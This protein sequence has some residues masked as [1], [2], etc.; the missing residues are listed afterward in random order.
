[1][2]AKTLLLS[3]AAIL[4]AAFVA[5]PLAAQSITLDPPPVRQPLDE[6]GVDLSSGSIAVP[7]STIAI[8]GG[9]GLV[10]SRSRVG[11]GWRH[12]YILSVTKEPV[13]GVHTYTVQIGGSAREFLKDT[14]GDFS[15]LSGERGTM[16][17]TT[18][19]IIYT[20][21]G[22][23]EYRF[24]KSLVA[25]GES[26][27]EDVEAVGT[28]IEAPNG[29]KTTLTY[30]GGTYTLGAATIHT[31]RLQSV[32]NNA[33]YQLKF[34]YETN[35]LNSSTV[36]DW[37][38]IDK[39]T[40]INNAEEYCNPAADSCS[41]AG[42]WPYLD[43]AVT[44]S[45]TE[46]LETVTDVLGRQS[47]FRNDGSERLIGVKRPSETTD[48]VVI[49]YDTNSRVSSVTHQG[50]Y[51]RNYTWTESSGELTAVAS[52]SLGRKRTTV[53]DIDKGVIL[54][55]KDA[56]NNETEY[57][58]DGQDRLTEVEAPEGN[59]TVITRDDRGRVTEVRQ[60]A[61]PGSGLAD[62]VTSAT[63][64]ALTSAPA[65]G[66]S[67]IYCNTD[68]TCDSPLTTTDARGKVTD[69]TYDQTHGGVLTVQLPADAGSVR[70]KSTF[71]YASEYARIRNSSGT[72]VQAADPI[73]KPVS[74]KRCRIG[75]SCSG[76]ANEQVI[77]VDYDNLQAA[78][79]QPVTITRKVGNGTLA[80]TSSFT[81]TPLGLV[82]TTDGPLA[83]S[84]DLSKNRYD[85]A[86][87]LVGT[88][89]PDPNG[90]ST[91]N[92]PLATRLTR[93]L[94]GQVTVTEN[95]TVP[96]LTDTDWANFAGDTRYL[97]S[98]DAFGRVET[99]AHVFK[100]TAAQ[101]SITQ[102]SYDAAGRLECTAQR[103]NAPLS[104]TTLPGDACTPMTAGANGDDRITR[105]YYDTADRVTEVWSG[106]GTSLAQQSV[107]MSY[108]ANGQTQWVE[109]AMDNRTEYT[110]DGFDRNIRI[111]YPDPGAA[112]TVKASD[113]EAITYDAGGNI[114]THRTR[115][116]ETFSYTYD[117]LSR[118]T[119]K[120]VPTRSGLAATHTR[121]VY[122]GYDLLGGLTYANFDSPTG[123][124]LSF[125]YDALG[126]LVSAT[127]NLDSQSRT[128]AY[129][130]DAAG[131][132]TRIT[133]PDNAWWTHEWD[134]LG[135]LT[136]IKD[137]AGTALVS[138]IFWA[139]GQLRRSSRDSSAPDVNFH[140]DPGMRLDEL[141]T[142]HPVG[143]YDV[144]HSW[145][146]NPAGQAADESTSNNIFASHALPTTTL[147]Y[148]ANG[149]NQYTQV[150]TN[151]YSY[152]TGGNLTSDGSTTFTYDTEN[153]L[154]SASGG[155]SATL[156]YDPFGR[157][158]EVVGGGNTT[159]F[160]YDG[161]ALVGE[162]NASGTLLQRYIHG[163]SAGDD[164]LIRYP[165]TGVAKTNAH[166]LYADRLGSIIQETNRSGTQTALNTYDP[167][168]VPG[169]STGIL[170]TGRFRYTGQAWIEELGMY[171]Y[172]A[173][174]YSPTLGRFM[175]T[176][177]IG[178][179]DGMNMYR[180]VGND[181]VN[182]I[183][184]AGTSSIP[185]LIIPCL[186]KDGRCGAGDS[187]NGIDPFLG[188][189]GGPNAYNLSG[190]N[191]S[192]FGGS[193]G[194]GAKALQ[195]NKSCGLSQQHR[196]FFD[197]QWKPAFEVGNSLN[198]NPLF[199][200]GLAAYES[201]Y[202]SPTA[203]NYTERNNPFGATPGGDAT[204]GLT[205]DSYSEAWDWWGEHFGPRIK[206]GE[207][208]WGFFAGSLLLDFRNVPGQ[209]DRRGSYNSENP[210]W[211]S[212]L[213]SV[214]KGTIFRFQEYL[215][216]CR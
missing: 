79:L 172:K 106:V 137:Q 97:T 38:Q 135:R 48:G 145:T 88:I 170:N 194:V 34:G 121:D 114:L 3:T 150:G 64:P 208:D 24:S 61:K 171:Y 26:Y 157:L 104:T 77:E 133:H 73:T 191:G 102:Y 192:L 56:L 146:L 96:G 9:D 6:N 126:Q 76:T 8:G 175:Q 37:Y 134:N 117:N 57:T 161:D 122:Y 200:L 86:G 54:S 160:H 10:H 113:Y 74:V 173:R 59:R 108:T 119:H 82:E 109:D 52:D 12:N 166:Y 18:S 213:L 14:N 163:V 80:A 198:V 60:K 153:R 47:R 95:G 112:H 65:S 43:Y 183:D 83:G 139:G 22:G 4:P 63:Y 66:G 187:P 94:D 128:L 147:D 36:D 178:Y 111:T 23:T 206:N 202:G 55:S 123:E 141:F 188:G 211:R 120:D 67:N 205:F 116:G 35:T 204:L 15:P 19:E 196:G 45:G 44:T 93:N 2:R 103:M 179:A 201:G 159:R 91:G 92:K 58:Y 195:Q 101:Y 182:F 184:P 11:N 89:S 169:P 158:Y 132:R 69:Y 155:N 41:L 62:I 193:W 125:T 165:G 17:E 209:V 39:V 28:Q 136:K 154:V 53:A 87:Q 189:M 124:G 84:A 20:D 207:N 68:V 212:N 13:L 167:Y 197:D 27:Y 30:K 98:Y 216:S 1:M 151:T 29:A 131:R 5:S 71:A 127:T 99:Q 51:T 70:P 105:N 168:G 90:A 31:I 46:Q 21:A 81:Y 100:S 162:Y 180:Y 49:A 42:I 152:D 144:T 143:T 7:S 210:A 181:P 32:A 138:N 176:D 130:Y 107:E 129:Q 40:A 115:R 16:S 148:T 140:Y 177:P 78:N 75:A 203:R 215:R 118:V 174:M 190:I 110:Q 33:S 185:V 214:T 156:R 50:S 199:L 149:L 72:L 186:D 25:N 142:N 85:D 164:P